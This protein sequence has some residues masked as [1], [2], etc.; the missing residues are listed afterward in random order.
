[1]TYS[2]GDL[3]AGLYGRG[4]THISSKGTFPLLSTRPGVDSLR[5]RAAIDREKANC[6]TLKTEPRSKIKLRTN[7]TTIIEIF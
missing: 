5:G 1:M 6:K 7:Y 3:S 4:E 2:E